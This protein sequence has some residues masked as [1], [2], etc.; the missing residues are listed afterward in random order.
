MN[1]MKYDEEYIH[2]PLYG[3]QDVASRNDAITHSD[4]YVKTVCFTFT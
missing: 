3:I 2:V 1:M 4:F